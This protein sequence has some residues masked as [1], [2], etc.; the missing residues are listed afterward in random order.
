MNNS[1]K[2]SD[3]LSQLKQALIALKEMRAKLD[4]I[5]QTRTEPIAI[6]GMGCRFPGAN[7]LKAFWQMLQEG[8]DAISKVPAD[9]WDVHA[10]YDPDPMAPG[11]I[12]TY[13]GGF[14][15]QID[16]FDPGFFGI[17]PREATRMDPQQRLLLEVAWEALENAG[18]TKTQLAGSQ[19]GVF[20]GVHSHSSDYWGL[21]SET[22]E[23]LD[24]YSG[25][26][27]AHSVFSGRLSYLLDL[28]GPSLV[29][30]TAC[31]SSLVAVHLACQSLRA[32]ETR[33]ALAGGVNLMVLPLFTIVTSKM[34]MLAA[35]GRCKVF[36]AQGD[37][38]VRGEG[39]GVVVLK[40]M[41]DAIADGD[42]ILALI[43]GSA[44]NQNGHANGLTALN[45]LAQQSVVH[46]ALENAR[47]KPSQISYIET[48]ATGTPLADSIEIEA[49]GEIFNSSIRQD[50]T[51]TLGS[52]KANIGHLEG[53]AGIAALIKTV[54]SLQHE[55]IPPLIHFT[56]LNP[57]I[58]LENTSFV[59]PTELQS[60]PSGA[61]SRFAG[62]SSFGW[63]G[64][65]AHVILE[66]APKTTA[67]GEWPQT[68][69]IQLLPL[70][71]HTL[72]ALISLAQS[73]HEFLRDGKDHT[74]NSLQNI[75]YTTSVRRHHHQCRLA[76]VGHSRQ[77]LINSIQ[78][79]LTGEI[80]TGIVTGCWN[81][82]SRLPGLVFI[83]PEQATR[84][85]MRERELLEEEPIFREVI[86]RCDQ[87][88]T[89]YTNWSLL[90]QM[91]VD[92]RSNLGETIAALPALL[93]TQIA[94]ATL[95][96]SWGIKPDAVV[97][98]GVGEVAAAYTTGAL[99]FENVIQVLIL[100]A[101]DT[102]HNNQTES[103]QESLSDILH[104]LKL[105]YT[106][107][108]DFSPVTGPARYDQ[109]L[110]ATGQDQKKETDHFAAT[111]KQLLRE[112]HR[113]FLEIGPRPVLL[114]ML[115]QHLRKQDQDSLL[116]ASLHPD[117]Q[118][119]AT[120]LTSLSALYAAGY[121]VN[122]NNLYP[123]GECVTQLPSY[124]WQY[125]RYWLDVTTRKKRPCLQVEEQ[126]KIRQIE[127]LSQLKTVSSRERLVLL[128]AYLQE[129]IADSLKVDPAQL[130][131]QRSLNYMGIDS[132]IATELRHRIKTGLGI[133]VPAVKFI[134]GLNIVDVATILDHQLIEAS[135]AF[136]PEVLLDADNQTTI[137]L[138]TANDNDWIEGEL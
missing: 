45:G 52:V 61:E 138:E 34:N 51:C 26:G 37:G 79:Y 137:Q 13:W 68:N 36:D 48:H 91:T 97:G 75:C 42:P 93:A 99:S 67:T 111:I 107:I 6:I 35:D 101:T 2:Q 77:E 33:V 88:I 104:G 132:L 74:A 114:P 53:A 134:E 44:V 47:V 124:P 105:Q 60:W 128:T 30:D 32:G 92:G 123:F 87:A 80:S 120:L 55:A 16:Q 106:S 22:P 7:T 73:Y 108:P 118:A 100:L 49:L 17:S 25:T 66:E 76:V 62:V 85:F 110:P 46:Q 89:P 5:E 21:Q 23:Q 41:S 64:A 10:F 112:D 29:V 131:I 72:E 28:Q 20:M 59:I 57:L 116:L 130:D 86:E 69:R 127:L 78:A 95:W 117:Q 9:R 115:D 83:F 119:R 4:A 113:V 102:P 3:S 133:N 63:S 90:E 103:R 122:W 70:S 65:N 31:S 121:P 27:T 82:E 43:R 12:N 39:C 125:K 135:D 54:L 15:E 126:S 81:M 94:L 11:K 58:S 38:L 19:T 18:Q 50:Q 24:I 40:R 14:L 1:A 136:T 84:Q 109:D 96:R 8:V 98:Y 129:Q 56:K 71:A